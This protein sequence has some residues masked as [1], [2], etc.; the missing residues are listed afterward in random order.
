[1]VTE[2]Y[3]PAISR[4]S[5]VCSA[6]L[7]TLIKRYAFLSLVATCF[8][9]FSKA[10]NSPAYRVPHDCIPCFNLTPAPPASR[11]RLKPRLG[12]RSFC[13]ATLLV[14]PATG[15]FCAAT[16]L[17]SWTCDVLFCLPLRLLISHPRPKLGACTRS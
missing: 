14:R 15:S 13:A 17:V 8:E 6:M 9:R 11:R 2:L 3:G 4:F 7:I 5:S 10:A 1:V 12:T 16:L